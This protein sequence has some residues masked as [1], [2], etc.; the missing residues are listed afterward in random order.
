MEKRAHSDRIK[1][2]P[3]SCPDDMGT[4][5]AS[6]F[7]LL[8]ILKR[9]PD[10]ML[11]CK[12]KEQACLHL[13]RLY[14]LYDVN[15]RVLRPPAEVETIHTQGRKSNKRRKKDSVTCLED[16]SE[17]L[18][19]PGEDGDPELEMGV[20]LDMEAKDLVSVNQDVKIIDGAKKGTIG[21]V[22]G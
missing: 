4:S 9:V 17:E 2:L 21:L 3:D 16:V 7:A 8:P 14:N 12:D 10:L 6:S 19:D 1:K 18:K 13:Y 22:E 15:P 5:A 20:E 11:E